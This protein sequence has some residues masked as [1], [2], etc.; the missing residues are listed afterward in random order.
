[1][2]FLQKWMICDGIS[3]KRH[4]KKEHEITRQKGNKEEDM[5]IDGAKIECVECNE[6]FKSIDKIIEHITKNECG[7]WTCCETY[8]RKQKE[9]GQGRET[10]D[11]KI[12]DTERE[13]NTQENE[14]RYTKEDEHTLTIKEPDI[15]KGLT[16]K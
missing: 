14:E 7:G 1:M 12:K 2:G 5:E 13:E 9:N 15:A 16:K 11:N 3:L 4:K 6:K 8:L 10:E